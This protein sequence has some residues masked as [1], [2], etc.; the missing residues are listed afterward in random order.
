MQETNVFIVMESQLK[1]L[2]G[3]LI[4]LKRFWKSCE[5][6][7]SKSIVKAICLKHQSTWIQLLRVP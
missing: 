7:Q 3:N 5:T 1:R 4:I 6:N 2:T